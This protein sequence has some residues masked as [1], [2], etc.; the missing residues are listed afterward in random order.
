MCGRLNVIDNPDVKLL[1]AFLGIDIG[2]KYRI[3]LAPT[4]MVSAAVEIDGKRAL[5]DMRWWLV[6]SWAPEVTTK[7]S[8][9]NA[10][11]E[12][13]A[14]SKAFREPFRHRRA[15]I[16]ASSFIEWKTI[17]KRK[18]PYLIAPAHGAIAFGAIW[19]TWEHGD[20][21]IESC[22]IITTAACPGFDQ[23][24]S[25]MPLMLQPDELD[26]WLDCSKAI[27]ASDPI[28]KPQLRTSLVVTPISDQAN[29][30]RHK[31]P[32]ALSPIGDPIIIESAA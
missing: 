27:S 15:I 26:R 30:A 22:A 24:H 11:A 16:P 31:D 8:M 9:F 32:A 21:Y 6:P 25:R 2:V 28:F 19:D 14:T 18:Q 4:E 13:L 20:N 3:N 10:K 5:H 7:Y 23:V 12:N 17:G 29:N 1:L